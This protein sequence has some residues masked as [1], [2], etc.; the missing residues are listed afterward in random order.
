MRTPQ[1][2]T[3]VGVGLL[4]VAIALEEFLAGGL[5]AVTLALLT[6]VGAGCFAAA[7]WWERPRE[8]WRYV[9]LGAV[10]C[11][12]YAI[13]Y[14]FAVLGTAP[15]FALRLLPSGLDAVDLVALPI[16]ILAWRLGYSVWHVTALTRT[17]RELLVPRTT[18]RPVS[19]STL[20][21]FFI[22]TVMVRLALIQSGVGYGYLRD[23]TEITTSVNSLA[24][25]SV[26]YGEFGVII[27][28]LSIVASGH[29][30]DSNGYRRLYVWMLPVEVVLR[31]FAGSKSALLLLAVVLVFGLAAAGTL[32]LS[33]RR[34]T[35]VG[36]VSLLVIFPLIGTYRTLLN[37]STGQK[38]S[39]AQ[40]P[41]VA[42]EA[43]TQT[44][45]T[46]AEGPQAYGQLAFDKTAGRFREIDRAAV[47]IQTHDAGR[48]YSPYGEVPLRV[49]TGLVPRLLWPGKP[50]NLYALD[51]SRNYYALSTNAISASSLSPVGDAYRYGGLTVVAIA[52]FLV[53]A[54]VRFLD[55]MLSPRSSIWLVP[56]LIAAIPLIRGGDLVGLLVGAIRYFL[57][58]GVFYR[59][60]FVRAKRS[61]TRAVLDRAVAIRPGP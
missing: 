41:A 59:L 3:S 50:L 56:L 61:T 24:Q 26:L 12:Y 10:F 34:L 7:L 8:S 22:T 2:L 42:V 30:P 55:E 57:V 4:V 32:K 58:V 54:F 38:V 9:S 28:G 53:G 18:L 21:A 60:L 47:S 11:L 20:L 25:Y 36:L 19:P 1:F 35:V 5:S 52:L 48:P 39:V 14:G 49:A 27:I 6:G 46:F 45:S 15:F 31:L 17:A 51:V 29:V 23:A 43:I 33:M 37:A 13:S 16:G 44:A 40:T